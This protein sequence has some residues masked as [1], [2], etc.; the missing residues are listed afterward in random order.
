MSNGNN[1]WN[2]AYS[3]I[4]WFQRLLQNHSNTSDIQRH[5]D[6]VFEVDRP[7]QGDHL[8]VL[9]CDEYVMGLTTVQRGLSEFGE[10][11]L[12]YIGGGWCGYT[13][14]AKQ[15]CI[16]AQIGVFVSNEMSGALWKTDFWNYHQR[17]KDRNPIYFHPRE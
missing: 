16:D 7:T 9:C 5:D 12:F 4:T 15:F 13:K 11:N 3:Q 2:V 6:I 8:R 14:E 10:I 17:D 1:D